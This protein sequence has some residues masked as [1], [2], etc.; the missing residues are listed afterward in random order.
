MVAAAFAA[1]VAPLRA[2]ALTPAAFSALIRD[3]AARVHTP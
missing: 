1:R 2:T 3:E